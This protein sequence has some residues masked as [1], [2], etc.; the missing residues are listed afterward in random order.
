MQLVSHY[1][2]TI[3]SRVQTFFQYISKLKDICLPCAILSGILSRHEK[4]KCR[5]IGNA[6]LCFEC[7]RSPQTRRDT[8]THMRT[9]CPYDFKSTI[10]HSPM[11]HRTCWRCGFGEDYL[12]VTVHHSGFGSYTCQIAKAIDL[13]TC[14]RANFDVEKWL[15]KAFP[16]LQKIDM[17]KD[18]YRWL[19]DASVQPVSVISVVEAALKYYTVFGIFFSDG[20]FN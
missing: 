12:G 14:L 15:L 11:A 8:P 16:V 5:T 13:T 9:N 17:G 7:F 20:K 19:F 4:T 10:L 3:R 18:Y 1:G 2:T 6:N